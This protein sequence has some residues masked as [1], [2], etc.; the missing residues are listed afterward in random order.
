MATVVELFD[1]ALRYH[2]SGNWQQAEPLYRQ[3]LHAD[4]NH[5]GAY[6]FL[7]AIAHQT[8]HH[9][10]A[11]ELV[12]HAIALNPHDPAYHYNLGN[13]LTEQGR[14]D[15]AVACYQRALALNP[16]YA[17]AHNN[18]GFVLLALEK[19]HEAL[20]CF[21]QALRIDPRG[22]EAYCNMGL[23]LADLGKFDE[24]AACFGHALQL[25]P[26]DAGLHLNLG[27]VLAGQGNGTQAAEQ[28]AQALRL[29]PDGAKSKWNRALLRLARGDLEQGWADYEHRWG[30]PGIIRRHLDRPR[31][32]GAPFE[33]ETLLLY[34]EQGLGDT[35]QFI[36]YAPWVKQRG[37]TVLFECQPTLVPALAGIPGVDHM[38]ALGDPPPPFDLQAPLL[39]L[40]GIFGTTLTTIP[41]TV[42]YLFADSARVEAWR[43]RLTALRGFK[44]GI[45]WQGGTSQKN[46]CLRSAPL[47]HFT[48]LAQV[49]GVCLVSLQKGHGTEE[50]RS[51]KEELPI[52]D[53]GEQ[54]D[55]EG[56]FT[57]TA[58]IMKNV[59]L[60]VT[61]DTAVAHLAGALGV[62]VWTVLAFM[63][64][65]RWLLER[66]DSP[67]YPTMR[68]F[69]QNQPCDWQPVFERV[70]DELRLLISSRDLPD[71]RLSE[72]H[73]P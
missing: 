22:E 42:P 9:E 48:A 17:R 7:G 13:I 63:P 60:V 44:V 20:E 33:G 3:I 4:P 65:W 55:A 66:P 19:R 29:P 5:S 41:A 21:Q 72:N 46:D 56:A 15:E 71:A 27:H 10:D 58:A 52:L 62:P 45:C 34:A 69:R 68:L 31:W 23:A 67:W 39:S 16:Q 43:N 12:R 70:A 2:Q 51:L 50:L 64:D 11:V 8:G 26:Q 40:P 49:A 6:L 14:R 57:D 54:L 37:G 61:V 35:F 25:T 73:H 1:L 30:V 59:D 36:R 53:L 24:A 47:T 32:D 18:L 38:S 28:Y